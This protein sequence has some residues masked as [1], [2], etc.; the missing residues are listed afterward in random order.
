MKKKIDEMEIESDAFELIA[1]CGDFPP[2]ESVEE[3]A[4]IAGYSDSDAQRLYQKAR[5][6]SGRENLVTQSKSHRNT[7][8]A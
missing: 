7:K 4:R 3:F 6:L 1:L 8:K 5:D 2:A